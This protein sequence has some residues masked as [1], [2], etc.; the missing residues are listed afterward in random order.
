[1]KRTMMIQMVIL[2]SLASAIAGCAGQD[3]QDQTGKMP[4][5]ELC[6]QAGGEWKEMP[7]A[8]V[9][10]CE[11]QRRGM[12]CAQVITEGCDCGEGMCWNGQSCEEL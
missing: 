3:A 7:D 9:D 10:S 8:C 5:Q 11:S 2:L 1:M 4:H 6:E 12:M